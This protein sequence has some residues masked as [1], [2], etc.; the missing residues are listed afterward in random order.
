MSNKTITAEACALAVGELVPKIYFRFRSRGAPAGVATVTE[1]GVEVLHQLPEGQSVRLGWLAERL[2]LSKGAAS[3]M[4]KKLARAGLLER[5]RN[6]ENEREVQ[7][8]LSPMGARFLRGNPILDGRRLAAYL[9]RHP[10]A[11]RARVVE[12]LRALVRP[13]GGGSRW[14]K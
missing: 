2:R 14:G 6:P 3:I 4:V 12:A 11:E 13:E 9:E 5:R 7:I 8:R 10:A 1:Y